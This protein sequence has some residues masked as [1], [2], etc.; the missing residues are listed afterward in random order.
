VEKHGDITDKSICLLT[1]CTNLY[2]DTLSDC[3]EDVP[4][5]TSEGLK[6]L[7]N[8][9][10]LTL[11]SS[12]NIEDEGI[13]NLTNL[14]CL[15]MDWVLEITGSVLQGLTNL[16]SLTIREHCPQIAD[17]GIKD[18]TNLTSLDLDIYAEWGSA[19]GF[20]NAGL[21]NL[22]NLTHLRIW[23]AEELVIRDTLRMFPKA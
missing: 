10:S 21:T 3:E 6:N 14:T 12:C 18:L 9:I 15:K 20:T 1:K 13:R 2:L 5:I 7:T 19:N 17:Q 11:E 4:Y 16:T 8:L 23:G 22:T